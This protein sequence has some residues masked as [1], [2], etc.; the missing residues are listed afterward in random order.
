[1]L[2]IFNPTEKDIQRD[3]KIPLY[4]T[5]IRNLA[6]IREQEGPSTEVLLNH[7]YEVEVQVT[8]KAGGFT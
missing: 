2:I 3:F 5:G 7:D 1:M 6:R 8:I 4:Y